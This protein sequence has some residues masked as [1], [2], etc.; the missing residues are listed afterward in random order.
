MGRNWLILFPLLF[1]IDGYLK[2]YAGGLVAQATAD[3]AYRLSS[4]GDDESSQLHC[5]ADPV[6]RRRQADVTTFFGRSDMCKV[7]CQEPLRGFQLES[8][9]L[10]QNERWRQA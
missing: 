6:N 8:L 4:F 3:L 1:D 9:I 5:L 2:R 7:R 10:A